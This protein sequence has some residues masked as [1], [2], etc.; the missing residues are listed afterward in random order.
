MKSSFLTLTV[1]RF[2]RNRMAVIGGSVLILLIIAAVAAPLLAPYDPKEMHPA[3]RLCAPS[4]LH[5]LGADQFGRDILSRLLYGARISLRVGFMSTGIALSLGL[6]LGLSAGYV[7][8]WV[9]TIIS[10]MLDIMFA[11]PFMLLAIAIMAVLGPSELNVI[12]TI[13]IV[14][15]PI[16]ARICR[17][18]TLAAKENEYIHAARL[19]GASDIRIATRHIMPNISA[20]II[21]QATLS[22]ATA[23]IA[24]AALSFLGVGTPPPAPSWGEMVSRGREVM[25]L[26]PWGTIFPAVAIFITVLSFNLL[27]D[28]LRDALD[29]MMRRAG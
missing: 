7:G 12:I 8:G 17:G 23:I 16:F 27:G 13:G 21:V 3:D 4:P 5:P 24:E 6:L 11:F 15:A 9:D 1:R 20:P 22:L 14:Y 19:V 26:S 28:G 25:E 10:R 2:F 18:S 29:P